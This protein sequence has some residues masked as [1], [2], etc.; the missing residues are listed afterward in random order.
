M[1]IK[2]TNVEVVLH[3]GALSAPINAV[4]K[5]L[6]MAVKPPSQFTQDHP[7]RPI[8][9]R[10]TNGAGA[11]R[12]AVLGSSSPARHPDSELDL[13]VRQRATNVQPETNSLPG[14]DVDLGAPADTLPRSLTDS[15][16]RTQDRQATISQQVS[17][18]E[19]I[20][21]DGSPPLGPA[22]A[23]LQVE[24]QQ[25]AH[26]AQIKAELVRAARSKEASCNIT[27]FGYSPTGGGHTART[28]NIIR[29]AVDKG[30][31][32]EGSVVV[33][34]L[35]EKW[36]GKERPGMLRDLANYLTKHG[37]NAI[38][39]E[40]EKSVLGF[41]NAD[42]SSDS[43]RI[44][45]HFAM[46]PTRPDAGTDIREAWLLAPERPGS[47]RLST[48]PSEDAV[49]AGSVGKRSSTASTTATA[50][51]LSAGPSIVATSPSLNSLGSTGAS[52]KRTANSILGLRTFD[53]GFDIQNL[54]TISA[55]SLM[56]TLGEIVGEDAMKS[57][58]FVLTDMDPTLQKAAY[59]AGV[60]R[61]H[62][63]DQQNHAIL[64]NTTGDDFVQ[65]NIK[66]ENALVGKILDTYDAVPSHIGLGDKNTLVAMKRLAD[67]LGL[68]EATTK[69]QA[70]D[71]VVKL[72]LEKGEAVRRLP[73][74]CSAL[75]APVAGI[76]KHESVGS[77]TDISNVVYVYAHGLTNRIAKKVQDELDRAGETP[78]RYKKT[79]FVFCGASVVPPDNAMHL[80]Y[81]AEGDGITTS[82]AG[83]HGEYAYLH[84]SG[85]SKA[86]LMALPIK[87]HPEQIANADKLSFDDRTESMVTQVKK[88]DQ[89]EGAVD[90]WLQERMQA[91]P[92]KYH[93]PA[94]NGNTMRDML[95]AVARPDTYVSQGVELLF[96]DKKPKEV[97]GK[98]RWSEVKRIE[99]VEKALHDSPL[100]AA[101]RG[102]SKMVFQALDIV[103]NN[104]ENDAYMEMPVHIKLKKGDDSKD[105]HF[106]N[107][108]KFVL[109]LSSIGGL[110]DALG[111]G[112]ELHTNHLP[113]ILE[114]RE[115]FK[116]LASKE[117]VPPG[118]E[119][120]RIEQKRERIE[121]F[122]KR[123]GSVFQT[124][125]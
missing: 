73:E 118:Q 108:E 22:D 47:K 119:R 59:G 40:A 71:K 98:D 56:K 14:S 51:E 37:V 104:L 113:K 102:F 29:E 2:G 95:N 20:V 92:A 116:E 55:S 49:D 96:G 44:S 33:F 43:P 21:T 57:K 10:R 64:L 39:A 109:A 52:S 53:K 5:A 50:P 36:L 66:S 121:D 18:P 16:V 45:E 79:M 26:A 88:Q 74:E 117:D 81:L 61:N 9:I 106:E 103:E 6:G 58:V 62:R 3:R 110:R 68:T 80:A 38:F 41:F 8:E 91:A 63:V 70:R 25:P 107:F 35:P 89:L 46:Q 67:K 48:A 78:D 34:H 15:P 93:D 11:P 27:V 123:F 124:G 84:F 13:D 1:K 85:G 65:S 97:Y 125:F 42:G 82:G 19:L 90:R 115:V 94:G 32:T 60:P 54:P 99:Q 24:Y 105:R 112:D 75:S 120:E 23:A 100:M 28:L 31:I 87:N 17:A 7:L 72:L 83:T 12:A 4:K 76:M 122:K 86:G 77:E 101:N 114:V 69:T 30:K 111:C